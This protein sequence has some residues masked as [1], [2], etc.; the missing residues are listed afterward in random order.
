MTSRIALPK[1]ILSRM[2]KKYIKGRRGS[3]L[4]LFVVV[5]LSLATDHALE[6]RCVVSRGVGERDDDDVGTV[7]NALSLSNRVRGKSINPKP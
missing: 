1:P 2:C 4:L 5:V 7:G 3:V 6:T